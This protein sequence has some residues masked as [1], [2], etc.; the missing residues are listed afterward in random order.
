MAKIRKI[1]ALALSSIIT[2]LGFS[3]CSAPDMYGPGPAPDVALMYGPAPMEEFV[4]E[5][6]SLEAVAPADET[7]QGVRPD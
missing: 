7:N 6:P 5:Q 1:W 4:P 2:G 3:A